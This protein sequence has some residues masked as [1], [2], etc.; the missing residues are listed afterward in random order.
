MLVI[1][2][3]YVLINVCLH[4]LVALAKVGTFLVVSLEN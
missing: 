1:K 4:L 2:V 3:E